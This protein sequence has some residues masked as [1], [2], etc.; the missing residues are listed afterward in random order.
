MILSVSTYPTARKLVVLFIECLQATIIQ[1]FRRESNLK[2]IMSH[3]LCSVCD[4]SQSKSYDWG[5]VWSAGRSWIYKS[6]WNAVP[7]GLFQYS[8]QIP[9]GYT[10]NMKFIQM[11]N[12]NRR[13]MMCGLGL[14]AWFSFANRA[15]VEVTYLNKTWT[16]N[17]LILHFAN[18]SCN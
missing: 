9:R 3:I 16:N 8:M 14:C 2:L 12:G 1:E 17:S 4:Q 18:K 13:Y 15:G 7:R 5:S 10:Y 11:V 6:E